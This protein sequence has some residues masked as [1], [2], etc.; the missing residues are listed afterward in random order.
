MESER[1]QAN[2]LQDV[3]NRPQNPDEQ[4]SNER[5]DFHCETRREYRGE[6]D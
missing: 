6:R 2:Q 1:K 3:A 5:D 4:I